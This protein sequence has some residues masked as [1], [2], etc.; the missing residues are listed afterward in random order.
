MATKL[1]GE[2]DR[3]MVRYPSSDVIEE[4]MDITMDHGHRELTLWVARGFCQT[5]MIKM[6]YLLLNGHEDLY[7][8]LR[9]RR[10]QSFR[11]RDVKEFLRRQSYYED[12]STTQNNAI[13]KILNDFPWIVEKSD[14][15][16]DELLKRI[17][18]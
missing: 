12:F 16:L 4:V 5:S 10:P 3:R 17:H 2:Y 7:E 14:I 18:D 9:L 6:H 1:F 11:Y 13:R 8:E 15:E